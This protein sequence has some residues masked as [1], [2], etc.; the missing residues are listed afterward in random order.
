MKKRIICD[1]N[2]NS[3][4]ANTK[5]DKTIRAI[6]NDYPDFLADE[7]IDTEVKLRRV[8]LNK[9]T[10]NVPAGNP[11]Y[12]FAKRAGKELT[13]LIDVASGKVALVPSSIISATAPVTGRFEIDGNI[14]E[15]K[16]TMNGCPRYRACGSTHKPRAKALLKK[17][18]MSID[19]FRLRIHQ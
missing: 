10:F 11:L 19:L 2:L 9:E 14:Y 18:L 16:D 3:I 4:V 7:T 17:S 1:A 8:T 6:R 5:A 13:A 15:L 12:A